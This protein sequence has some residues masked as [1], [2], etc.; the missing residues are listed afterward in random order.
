MANNTGDYRDQWSHLDWAALVIATKDYSVFIDSKGDLDWETTRDYDEQIKT[1]SAFVV[2]KHNAVLNEAASLEATPCDGLTG[3]ARRHFKRLIGEA[4]GCSL[5]HDYKGAQNM[6]VVAGRYVRAR[7]E[8]VSRYWYLSASFIAAMPFVFFGLAVWL[9]RS[10]VAR[11]FGT[12]GMWLSLSVAAGAV[13]AL[14]SVIGRG[15]KLHFDCSAGRRLH[16]LEAIS[17]ICAGAI[18]A[19]IVALA[20]ESEIVLAAFTRGGNTHIVM[21]LAGLASGAAERLAGS[22]ISKLD[23]TRIT[24]PAI[25]GAKDN[26]EVHNS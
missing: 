11:L 13:G 20:V 3:E 25:D 17:R 15:G 26:S 8:E 18:S 22:I 7:S 9:C 24:A 10:D 16:Y 19:L 2:A 21:I 14:L 12:E 23:S 6:L 1:D 4:I 5:D